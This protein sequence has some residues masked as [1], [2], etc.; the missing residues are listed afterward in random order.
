MKRIK[1]N[2]NRLNKI[3]VIISNL[4]KDIESFEN[5]IDDLIIL[6][7]YYGSNE[8]FKDKKNYELGKYTDI[9][10]GV[11]SEDE[12]WNLNEDIDSIFEKIELIKKIL[13]NRE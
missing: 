4:E 6:N 2:E 3:K 13:K 7:N 1:D 11:L 12:V 8:W 5:N 10:A 9:K